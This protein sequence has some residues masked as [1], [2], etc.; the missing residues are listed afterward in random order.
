MSIVTTNDEAKEFIAARVREA[1][2]L[3]D[4]NQKKLA[5]ATKETEMTISNVV[6]GKHVPDAA[7]LKRISEALRVTTDWLLSPPEKKTRRTA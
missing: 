2:A 4:M 1:L 5:Q 7:I 6:N 3:R